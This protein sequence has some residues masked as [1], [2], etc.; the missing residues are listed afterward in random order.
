M[1]ENRTY[2]KGR[3]AIEI[4]II[5]AGGGGYEFALTSSHAP[6]DLDEAHNAFKAL[7]RKSKSR[8][9]GE[10][11]LAY[12]MFRLG[13]MEADRALER[14]LERARKRE[15]LMHTFEDGAEAEANQ[16]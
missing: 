9:G 11:D 6:D 4:A 10:P 12:E 3:F 1:L 14:K 8:K 5:K 15:A 16:Q 7:A 13:H 2:R